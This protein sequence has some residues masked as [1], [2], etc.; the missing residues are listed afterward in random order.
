VGQFRL[1][2]G[3]H[4][5]KKRSIFGDFL[6]RGGVWKLAGGVSD[7]CVPLNRP[8]EK[9]RTALV[10]PPSQM[11]RVKGRKRRALV[12]AGERLAGESGPPCSASILNQIFITTMI[13]S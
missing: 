8:R 7:G 12:A 3:A 10:R 13:G 1:E 4:F 5:A 6:V 9:G 2:V 11:L